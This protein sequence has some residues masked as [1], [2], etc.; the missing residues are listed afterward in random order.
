MRKGRGERGR[1][2]WPLPDHLP[3]E[4]L[5]LFSQ[6]S[7]HS[8]VHDAGG[9]T[10]TL[11]LHS[12]DCAVCQTQPHP[13]FSSDSCN[14]RP[15]KNFQNHNGFT[16][17]LFAS[18]ELCTAQFW[19]LQKP[20]RE[21]M[22]TSFYRICEASDCD[23]QITL[24]LMPGTALLHSSANDKMLLSEDAP[25]EPDKLLPSLY[26]DCIFI[27]S[28]WWRFIQTLIFSS[29]QDSSTGSSAAWFSQRFN[30]VTNTTLSSLPTVLNKDHLIKSGSAKRLLLFYWSWIQGKREVRR[31]SSFN[32]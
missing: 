22:L 29:L 2:L 31:S 23:C 7:A 10:V 16:E 9:V 18:E 5:V 12:P 27:L 15:Y 8:P 20:V 28:L 17:T 1:G 3:G 14:S 25:S 4:V 6:F 11:K 30:I 24:L 19:A 26:A 32:Y 21:E 13:P